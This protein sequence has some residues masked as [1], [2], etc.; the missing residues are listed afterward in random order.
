MN[1]P[2][3]HSEKIVKNARKSGGYCASYGCF[4]TM[5]ARLCQSLVRYNAACDQI[6]AIIGK[7]IG[8][9]WYFLH[10]YNK[11]IQLALTV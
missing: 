11:Q 10:H 9:I 5:A 4:R 8:A 6:I 7:L 3:C 2:Y 1:F